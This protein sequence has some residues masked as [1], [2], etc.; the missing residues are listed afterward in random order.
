VFKSKSYA[1]GLEI[2]EIASCDFSRLERVSNEDVLVRAGR[3]GKERLVRFLEEEMGARQRFHVPAGTNAFDLARD[4]LASLLEKSPE[5]RQE[6]EFLI[7]CGISNAMP[8]VCHAALLANELGFE[9]ASAWDLKSGCSTGVLGLAQAL[10]WFQ[11][12]AKVGVLVASE[13]FSRFTDPSVLEMAAST[14][15][16]AAAMS[17]RPSTEWRVRGVLHGTDATLFKSA[18]V[19][20]K[21]PVDLATYRAEDYVFAFENKPETLIALGRHWVTSL[22]DLLALSGIDGNAVTHYVAHQVD[23]SKNTAFAEAC[24]VPSGAIAKSFAEYGNMGC[25]TVFVNYL[26]M[27]RRGPAFRVGDVLVLHAVGG[28]VSYAGICLEKIA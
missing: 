12:G 2:R 27:L 14:G 7:Y 4:A 8:T 23:G 13:T 17:L 6:A 22:N 9:R 1:T 26:G 3:R 16:G 11:H 5:L 15:D 24:G 19:P 18:W 20:G 28:G 21:Y 10:D 25:P